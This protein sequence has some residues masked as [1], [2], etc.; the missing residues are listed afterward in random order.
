[1][2]AKEGGHPWEQHKIV[3]N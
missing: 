3:S 1:M 2:E